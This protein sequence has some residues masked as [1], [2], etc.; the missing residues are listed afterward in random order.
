[1]ITPCPRRCEKG[2]A[3]RGVRVSRPYR[4][5][6]SPPPRAAGRREHLLHLLG[7]GAVGLKP[8]VFKLD[9]AAVGP[10]RREP[11]FDLGPEVGIKGVGAVELPGERNAGRRLQRDDLAPIFFGAVLALL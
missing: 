8:A 6:P 2:A 11:G 7:R 1:M 4:P 3:R 9:T 5:S 10:G